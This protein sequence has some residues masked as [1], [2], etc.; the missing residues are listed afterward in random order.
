MITVSWTR[1]QFTGYLTTWSATQKYIKATGENPVLSFDSALKK[2]WK[3]KEL[4]LV[5][6]PVFL[7]LGVIG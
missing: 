2:L 5:T 7:K 3:D 1:E 6:L 4:R